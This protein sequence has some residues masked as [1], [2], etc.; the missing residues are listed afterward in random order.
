M[1]TKVVS[2]IKSE[3]I[4]IYKQCT[5]ECQSGFRL[6]NLRVIDTNSRNLERHQRWWCFVLPNRALLTFLRP[7]WY[8]VKEV[9]PSFLLKVHKCFYEFRELNRICHSIDNQ[10]LYCVLWSLEFVVLYQHNILKQQL[11]MI[12]ILFIA[13]LSLSWESSSILIASLLRCI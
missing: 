1:K 2:H 8:L 4:S 12:L 7:V 13:Q 3:N 6:Q 11:G 9:R 10:A 5:R